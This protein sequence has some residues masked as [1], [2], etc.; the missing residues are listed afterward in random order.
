MALAAAGIEYQP[1][2][3]ITSG[4]MQADGYSAMQRLLALH[5]RPTAVFTHN[6]IIALGAMRAIY[7][8][9]LAVPQDISI[10]GYDDIAAAAYLAPPLTTVRSPKTEMG[11]LAARTILQLVQ[12]PDLM[13]QTVTLPVELIVRAS[14]AAVAA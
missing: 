14:T 4:S 7:D 8:E 5:Q 3:V 9:G 13:A 2:L 6:D 1:E 11:I 10:V 12:E